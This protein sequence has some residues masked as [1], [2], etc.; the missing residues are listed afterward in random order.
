MLKIKLYENEIKKCDGYYYHC[1][2]IDTDD[3]NGYTSIDA[4]DTRC[5]TYEDA[6]KELLEYVKQM[7]DEL[8]DLLKR[9]S[10]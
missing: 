4:I 10:E 3:I 9:E 1:A 7:R 6:K 2:T 8:D 5:A